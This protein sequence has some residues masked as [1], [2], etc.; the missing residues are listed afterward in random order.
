MPDPNAQPALRMP[1]LHLG[2]P[3][4][5]GPLTVFPVWTD[6]PLTSRRPYTTATGRGATVTELERRSPASGTCR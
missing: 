3:A 6:S 1:G 4:T 5:Y 2:S